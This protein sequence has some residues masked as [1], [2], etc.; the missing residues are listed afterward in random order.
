M[1]IDHLYGR[2][3]SSF[4]RVCYPR[5]SL[6]GRQG[7]VLV[8]RVKVGKI[9]SQV[10]DKVSLILAVSCIFK[11]ADFSN[12]SPAKYRLNKVYQHELVCRSK[13]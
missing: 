1:L 9:I 5:L 6:Y 4:T 12:D 8:M 3:S 2:L 7:K 13:V 10:I 11:M